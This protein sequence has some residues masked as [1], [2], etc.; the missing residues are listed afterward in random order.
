VTAFY[1][2]AA[3]ATLDCDDPWRDDQFGSRRELASKFIPLLQNTS[4][5][6]V[7]GIDSEYGTGKTFFLTRLEQDIKNKGGWVVSINA[8]A[9][10][11]YD[12]PY[13][14]F[15]DAL[16]KAEGE[17]P[18][19]SKEPQ[20]LKTVIKSIIPFVAKQGIKRIA[21]SVLGEGTYE[22][23]SEIIAES[24]EKA[25][26]SF[27][28]EETV[29]KN[30]EDVKDAL[31]T[32]VGTH[33]HKT[34]QKDENEQF[35]SLIILVDELDRV[36]PDFALKFLET[37]KHL[38]DVTGVIF[39]IAA[40]KKILDVSARHTFGQ[41]LPIDGYFRRLFDTWITLPYYSLEEYISKRIN[42]YK[43][44]EDN[45]IDECYKNNYIK[46]LQWR[47]NTSL[48]FI[49]QAVAHLNY[50]LRVSNMRN[51]HRDAYVNTDIIGFMQSLLSFDINYY[52]TYIG[53][54]KN[55]NQVNIEN[56]ETKKIISLLNTILSLQ[57]DFERI[58]EPISHIIVCTTK[59]FINQNNLDS[60]CI[61]HMINLSDSLNFN[62]IIKGYIK[63][64]GE[65]LKRYFGYSHNTRYIPYQ[66]HE[67]MTQFSVR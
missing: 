8:W 49:D 65:F 51:K 21:D 32:F 22:G 18:Q 36:R 61:N 46:G 47:E 5:P 23:A 41:D 16:K 17:I 26:E 45:F 35:R 48:R 1:K 15:M 58:K 54:E 31:R 66:I 30:I 19:E 20:K 25:A 40:D 9:Y 60:D 12:N 2:R 6:S 11:Q 33:L 27:L 55:L 4:G 34:Y 38:F 57:L 53:I 63:D 3:L 24:A 14:S 7:F 29:Q 50:I 59:K 42:E 67:L 39:V 44:V 52:N 56:Q 28:K 62:P 43:L 64:S 13:I 10:E 37:I